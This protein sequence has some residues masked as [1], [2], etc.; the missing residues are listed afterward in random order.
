MERVQFF[1]SAHRVAE[2]RHAAALL[3]VVGEETYALLRIL[4]DFKVSLAS[5]N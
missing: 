3:S 4:S 1:L 2:E 5:A